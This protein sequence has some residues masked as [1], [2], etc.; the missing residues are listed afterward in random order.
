MTCPRC[1]GPLYQERAHEPG[2]PSIW[3]WA[4][5]LCGHRTDETIS[6]NHLFRREETTAERHARIAQQIRECVEEVRL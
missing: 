2:S 1:Q 5:I 6:F 3:L 4:C